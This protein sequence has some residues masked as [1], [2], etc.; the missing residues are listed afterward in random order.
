MERLSHTQKFL[1]WLQC[2]DYTPPWAQQGLG[3][4]TSQVILVLTLLKLDKLILI[5][6]FPVLLSEKNYK[7]FSKGI[8]LTENQQQQSN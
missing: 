3:I 1:F 6:L 5:T 2:I 7:T 4:H 8:K